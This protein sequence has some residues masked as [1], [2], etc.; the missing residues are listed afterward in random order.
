M[1][2]ITDTQVAQARADL[3]ATG[4]AVLPAFVD[5][6]TVDTMLAEVEPALTQAF[7]KPTKLICGV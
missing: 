3:A 4:A 7:F 2:F 6:A 1:T 5:Q